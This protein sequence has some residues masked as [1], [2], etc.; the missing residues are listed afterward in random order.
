MVTKDKSGT[1]AAM[2]TST[3]ELTWPHLN[4]LCG[5]LQK[6]DCQGHCCMLQI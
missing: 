2:V 1:V 6:N 4:S 3:N 5:E